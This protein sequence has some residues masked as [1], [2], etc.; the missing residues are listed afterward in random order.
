VGRKEYAC[1]KHTQI[2]LANVIASVGSLCLCFHLHKIN[3]ESKR[4]K[5][6]GNL[7]AIGCMNVHCKAKMLLE[8]LRVVQIIA[9]HFLYHNQALMIVLLN[10]LLII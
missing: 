4:Y 9:S 2:S 5:Y 3:A 10:P 6:F 7:T 8:V 1:T